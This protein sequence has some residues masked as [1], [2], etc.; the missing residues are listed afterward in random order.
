M[1]KI[2]YKDKDIRNWFSELAVDMEKIQEIT[3]HLINL[4]DLW[5]G[6]DEKKEIAGT[7]Q[8]M[9]KPKTQPSN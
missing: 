1:T 6:Y 5:K 2:I 8:K 7:L 4:Y 9:P 3:K